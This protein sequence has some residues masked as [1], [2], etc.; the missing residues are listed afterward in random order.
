VEKLT[1]QNAR[2]NLYGLIQAVNR[3]QKP[4]LI[5]PA[6]GNGK[7]AAVL[8]SKADW[9]ALQETLYLGNAGVLARVRERRQSGGD[10]F[11]EIDDVDWHEL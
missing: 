10:D 11:F 1:P 2:K 4:I 5:A 8:V 7:S 9:D 6:N 3:Q